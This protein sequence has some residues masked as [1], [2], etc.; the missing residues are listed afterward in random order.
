MS[1]GIKS[2][3]NIYCSLN[4]SNLLEAKTCSVAVSMS[5]VAFPHGIHPLSFNVTVR[6]E[7]LDTSRLHV[8]GLT[9]TELA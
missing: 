9:G 1:S 6:K 7:P 3:A 4:T 5:T 2:G 8:L